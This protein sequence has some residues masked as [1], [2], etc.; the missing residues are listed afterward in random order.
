M[1][2]YQILPSICPVCRTDKKSENGYDVIS[3]LTLS[4]RG[5]TLSEYG[6]CDF[7]I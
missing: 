1:A 6:V 2:I 7:D 4:V 3:T 5:S